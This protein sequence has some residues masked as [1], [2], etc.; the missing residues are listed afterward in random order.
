MEEKKR[1]QSRDWWNTAR[2][3]KEKDGRRKLLDE[4]CEYIKQL[5]KEGEP[6][7]EIARIMEGICSR[8]TIQFVLFPER[9]ERVKARA[10]EVKRW[11]PYN[12]AEKR[13]VYMRTHRG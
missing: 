9:M 4:D 12:T 2:I 6:I 10:K 8:R 13:R 11:E 5:H 3:G 1:R 7:R